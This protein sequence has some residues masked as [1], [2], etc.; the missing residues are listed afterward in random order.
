MGSNVRV[1]TAP[2]SGYCY[3]VE[4]AIKTAL[5]VLKEGGKVVS[6][7]PLIHNP[8]VVRELESYGL[9]QAQG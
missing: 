5:E 1:E 8:G 3:G 9:R 2:Y 6:L 7:G 4:R